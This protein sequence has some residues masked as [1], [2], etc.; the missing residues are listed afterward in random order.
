MTLKELRFLSCQSAGEGVTRAPF[1]VPQRK[2]VEDHDCPRGRGQVAEFSVSHSRAI[3]WAPRGPTW[4]GPGSPSQLQPPLGAILLPWVHARFVPSLN[5]TTENGLWPVGTALCF[6]PYL[7]L[8]Q[9]PT[10]PRPES[11][12]RPF[13]IPPR[14]LQ[15]LR[16]SS[17]P[18][19]LS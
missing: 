12:H 18:F 19:V 13:Q 8:P 15:S 2:C 9:S 3:P 4:Q 16:P 14:H 7:P 17:A 11:T 10:A 5:P 6:C 1:P